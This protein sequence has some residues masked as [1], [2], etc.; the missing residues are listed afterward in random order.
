MKTE[1]LGIVPNRGNKPIV[2]V[3]PGELMPGIVCAYVACD[4]RDGFAF[5]EYAGHNWRI[6]VDGK[7]SHQAALSTNAAVPLGLRAAN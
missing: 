5:F 7:P 1:F 6:P 3:W 4:I 2:N